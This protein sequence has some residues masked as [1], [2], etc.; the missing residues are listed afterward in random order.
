[1]VIKKGK[2]IEIDI[3]NLEY[4]IPDVDN[5]LNSIGEVDE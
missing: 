3:K 4:H 5:P 1:M 2:W